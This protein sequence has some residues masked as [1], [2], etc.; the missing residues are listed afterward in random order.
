MQANVQEI[1]NADDSKSGAEKTL[2]KYTHIALLS[3]LVLM[4]LIHLA[5]ASVSGIAMPKQIDVRGMPDIPR[6]QFFG[7]SIAFSVFLL[8]LGLQKWFCLYHSL[9]K[10]LLKLLLGNPPGS[11]DYWTH[12]ENAAL[13][14]NIAYFWTNA[15][16]SLVSIIFTLRI[17]RIFYANLP[18]TPFRWRPEG[19]SFEVIFLCCFFLSF[20]FSYCYALKKEKIRRER[21]STINRL[22]DT[23]K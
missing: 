20:F 16:L 17:C 10:G 6:G 1:K 7:M 19:F 3:V 12:E 14:W 23:S 21:E 2:W 8:I 9:R 18:T 5:M 4:C 15:F 13:E 11:A 22:L